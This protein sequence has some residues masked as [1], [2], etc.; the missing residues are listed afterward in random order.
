VA[1]KT[2]FSLFDMDDIL[3]EAG[4]ASVS[5]CASRKLGEVLEDN[6]KEVLFKARQLSA[7]AGRKEVTRQ[8]IFLAAQLLKLAG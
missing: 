7:H 1:R 8:D 4:A 5:E 3:R 2:V 6:A